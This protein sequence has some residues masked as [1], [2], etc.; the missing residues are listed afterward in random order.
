M[1][2]Q[3]FGE[4][5]L[6]ELCAFPQPPPSTTM[7][8]MSVEHTHTMDLLHQQEYQQE[9][10]DASASGVCVLQA[11]SGLQAI[12]SEEHDAAMH[13]QTELLHM[14]AAELTEYFEQITQVYVL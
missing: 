6:A 7:E 3:L 9:Y 8:S 1:P 11:L 2:G 4:K 10:I 5:S 13:S 12:A 14:S